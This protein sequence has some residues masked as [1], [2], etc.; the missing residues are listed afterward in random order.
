MTLTIIE[1]R[2][3][4]VIIAPSSAAPSSCFHRGV[5]HVDGA[6]LMENSAPSEHQTPQIDC[7]GRGICPSVLA[8]GRPTLLPRRPLTVLTGA[9]GAPTGWEG[10]RRART[11]SARPRHEKERQADLANFSF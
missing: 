9:P 7:S 4:P 1:N 2:S 10:A 8:S 11:G 5:A 6:M 3:S